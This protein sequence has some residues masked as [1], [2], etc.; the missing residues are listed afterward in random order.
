MQRRGQGLGLGRGQGRGLGR[1][2]G[3]GRMGRQALG[4]GGSCICPSCGE[5]IPHK[6][7]VPCVQV[8]C[9][10]CGARMTRAV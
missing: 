8:D 4:V 6:T 10:K 7:G 9:P 2:V 1:G 5:K 3:L